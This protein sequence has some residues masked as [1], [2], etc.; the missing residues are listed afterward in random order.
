MGALAFFPWLRLRSEFTPIRAAGFQLL[1]YERHEYKEADAE[2]VAAILAPY[3]EV[4]RKSLDQAAL[5]RID[6]RA[7]FDGWEV[8]LI[9]SAFQFAEIVAFAGLSSRQFFSHSGYSNR[10][11]YRLIVQLFDKPGEGKLLRSPRRDGSSNL[12]IADPAHRV[13]CPVH[14]SRADQT[15]I[16]DQLLLAL[17]SCRSAANADDFIE[18]MVTFN[19]ANTDN[20]AIAQHV[21]LVLSSGALERVLHLRHGKEDQLASALV[22]SLNPSENVAVADCTRAALG[23]GK[24]AMVRELWVRDL[25]RFRNEF[26]HGNVSAKRPRI[27]SV[28]EH[29]LLSSYVFPLVMKAELA[30]AGFYSLSDG[31]RVAIDTFE[32]LVCAADLFATDG[33][34]VFIWHQIIERVRNAHRRKQ[35]TAALAKAFPKLPPGKNTSS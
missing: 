11:H 19:L 21:E 5:L 18:S 12:Y 7:I 24:S 1:R 13:E 35:A 22:R 3:A 26:A 25:Y 29:L 15:V 8:D 34:G 14:V 6:D 16:D 4:A 32:P 28:Q 10:D 30:A 2:A 20:P 17:V 23:D 27:W 31:D 33:D 9:D